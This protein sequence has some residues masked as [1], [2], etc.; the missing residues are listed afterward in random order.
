M[1]DKKKRYPIVNRMDGVTFN[2]FLIII[3]GV[4][5]GLGLEPLIQ[6]GFVKFLP[7]IPLHWVDLIEVVVAFIFAYFVIVKIRK[8]SR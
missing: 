8:I 5:G 1:P 4:V 2:E 6:Y 3:A 7:I